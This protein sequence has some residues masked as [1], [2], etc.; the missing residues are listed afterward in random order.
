MSSDLTTNSRLGS[1][2]PAPTTAHARLRGLG[3]RRAVTAIVV[4]VVLGAITGASLAVVLPIQGVTET[5]ELNNGVG[6]AVPNYH[7]PALTYTPSTLA[8]CTT[9]AKVLTLATAGTPTTTL[10]LSYDDGS[11]ADKDVGYEWAY[12]F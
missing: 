7:N 6:S 3:F 2:S 5:A 10:E 1:R 12:T 9:G 4:V 11:C 8:A